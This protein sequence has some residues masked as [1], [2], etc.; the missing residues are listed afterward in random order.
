M[1]A[2]ANSQRVD[3]EDAKHTDALLPVVGADRLPAAIEQASSNARFAYEE[4]FF[5]E[6]SNDHT[7][8]AYRHAVHR[9]LGWIDDLGVGLTAITPKMVR[10][11]LDRLR[12][13]LGT[14]AERQAAIATEKLHLSALRHFFDVC[15][16]RHAIVLNPAASVR[17][18]KYT[19]VEGK[20]PEISVKQARRL[21]ESI[22][23]STVVGLRDRAII[24]SMIYTAARVGAV[25]KLRVADFYQA[26]NQWC[27]RFSE[28]GG[29]S[30][31]IPVRH[32]LQGFVL[33]YIE[34]A[35]LNPQSEHEKLFCSA[36][37]RTTRLTDRSMT[38][39]DI[40]RMVKRRIRD[41]GLSPRLSPHS[42]RVCT[43]TDLLEQD[44]P[45]EDVQRLA[46][47][48]DPRTTRL[49]DRRKK[50]ITRNIVERISV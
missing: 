32:D 34:I 4:F 39:N 20:T 8:L 33:E 18:K 49:Y 14:K 40:C 5:G 3:R 23:T 41:A 24:A 15:V 44:V 13:D 16:T 31:E 27:F 38:A 10:N 43:I 35:A 11:Y 46:G 12:V 7:R 19:V 2:R 6:I 21:L 36:F 9:F 1:N 45:L 47:H 25:A 30:R 28:K 48:A 29:K 50:K 42:F 22:D 37:G 26:G 17:G